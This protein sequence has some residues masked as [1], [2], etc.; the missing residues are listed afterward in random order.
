MGRNKPLRSQRR[1]L[2]RLPN[3]LS[4][5]QLSGRTHPRI[6]RGI[7]QDAIR[8]GVSMNFVIEFHL[9]QVYSVPHEDIFKTERKRSA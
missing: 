1:I 8:F 5:I 9:A 7:E 4:R 2:Q 6:R 3:G